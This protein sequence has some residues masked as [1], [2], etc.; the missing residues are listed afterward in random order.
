M[1]V[2]SQESPELEQLRQEIY[3]LRRHLRIV[4]HQDKAI[5]LSI[6]AFNLHRP[7][8]QFSTPFYTHPC[9][10]KICLR[11]ELTENSLT[12]G[13]YDFV[14]H[15]CLMKGEFDLELAWPVKAKVTIQIRNQNGD[16]DHIKRSKQISWQYKSLGDPLPISVMTNVDVN[17]LKATGVGGAAKYV[18]RDTLQLAVKYMALE[19]TLERRGTEEATV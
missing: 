4:S 10:H 5:P 9:G 13:G 1:A 12:P 14:M 7:N 15:A 6:T 18:V 3:A 8:F 2:A 11:A 19:K 16:F 17:W